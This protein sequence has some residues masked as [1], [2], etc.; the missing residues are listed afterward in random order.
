MRIEESETGMIGQKNR[1]MCM[2]KVKTLWKQR[3]KIWREYRTGFLIEIIFLCV[4]LTA[5]G[6]LIRMSQKSWETKLEL[7]T[8]N[9]QNLVNENLDTRK[10]ESANDLKNN[11]Y[12]G[13]KDILPNTENREWNSK[14]GLHLEFLDGA[15][16]VRYEL[17]DSEVGCIWTTYDEENLELKKT[18]ISLTEYFKQWNNGAQ[19]E[20]EQFYKKQDGHVA[21]QKLK[22]YYNGKF[23]TVREMQFQS[24]THEDE[25]L[26]LKTSSAGGLSYKN[27]V[28]RVANLTDVSDGELDENV[29]LEQ[30]GMDLFVFMPSARVQAILINQPGK[31]QAYAEGNI[32]GYNLAS[33]QISMYADTFY[34]ATHDGN[35][36][37]FTLPIWLIG[38]AAAVFLIVV[39][40]YLHKKRKELASLR[41][42]FINA[43]AHEMKTPAAVIKNS[44]ECLEDGIHPE[45]QAN[46]IKMIQAEADHMNDLL[47]SMLTY[48]R[49]SDSEYDLHKSDC[50]LKEMMEFCSA[51]YG[52]QI[53]KKGIHVVWDAVEEGTINAD[54]KML[55]MVMD[56]FISNAVRFCTTGGVIR[57]TVTKDY[58]SVYNEG[59]PI[60]DDQLKAIWT[61]M[62]LGDDSRTKTS[63]TSGM[64]LA[65]SAIIL[66]AHHADYGVSNVAEGVEFY[67]KIPS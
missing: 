66:K 62:Y 39:Y 61:P 52:E 41:N 59:E 24:T 2:N 54:E 53:E 5:T 47:M 21:V 9:V 42:T 63:G 13:L 35:L 55:S 32:D 22:G 60:P 1:G 11:V 45:K 6:L 25:T 28:Y 46:Y 16:N 58:V 56:N 18:W 43:M 33:Y 4:A 37:K 67:F 14:L 8:K 23:F 29:T 17:A 19:Q 27:P 30:G 38:Q 7:M 50:S 10:S 26:V 57:L 3:K 44:A 34:L 31:R 48:T 15:D 40:L 12:I 36:K 49:L 65:I 51:H 20:F 64:G